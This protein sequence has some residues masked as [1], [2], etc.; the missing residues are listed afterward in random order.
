MVVPFFISASKAGTRKLNI[1]GL[2]TP[3]SNAKRKINKINAI[4]QRDTED[5]LFSEHQQMKGHKN[6]ISDQEKTC[7]YIAALK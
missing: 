5:A 2:E 1:K 4:H 6:S 3:S 7:M